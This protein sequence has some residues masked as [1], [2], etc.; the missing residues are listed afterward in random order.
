M[1]QHNS[2]N[3]NKNQYDHLHQYYPNGYGY[4][5]NLAQNNYS[6]DGLTNMVPDNH[7]GQNYPVNTLNLQPAPP[8]YPKIFQHN[9][10]P[11]KL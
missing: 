5:Q 11:K 3:I 9:K 4:P 7:P 10:V 6:Y 8:N 1:Y 2:F